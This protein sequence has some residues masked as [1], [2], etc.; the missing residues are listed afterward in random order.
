MKTEKIP[1]AVEANYKRLKPYRDS[2]RILSEQYTGANWSRSSSRK[3]QPLNFIELIV[4]TYLR[5][6]APARPR[7]MCE[8]VHGRRTLAPVCA[9]LEAACNHLLETIGFGDTIYR[10]ALEAMFS[11]GVA[12]VGLEQTGWIELVDSTHEVG[13]PFVD[14]V[15]LDDVVMDMSANRWDQMLFIG[16]CWTVPFDLA[17]DEGMFKGQWRRSAESASGPPDEHMH[18]GSRRT[19][20]LGGSHS[21][22]ADEGIERIVRCWTIYLPHS[23]RIVKWLAKPDGTP[24][25]K[26]PWMDD[27]WTGPEGG[28]YHRLGYNEVPGNLMPLPPVANIADLNLHLNEVM[29]KVMRQMKRQKTIIGVRAG[30]G[31]DATRINEADDGETIRMDDPAS[32][33]EAS[34]G[35]ADPATAALIP[36]LRSLMSYMAGNLDSLAGLSAAADTL[37]QER[38]I[39]ASSSLRI[40]DM[41]RKTSDFVRGVVKQIAWYVWN[42]PVVEYPGEKPIGGTGMTLP[43]LLTAEKRELMEW[44][45]MNVS[46]VPYS[47]QD[48][49]PTE[50]AMFI[51][52]MWDRMVAAAPVLAQQGLV[53]SAEAL[54]SNLAELTNI[55]ELTDIVEQ[56]GGPP[57]QGG[58]PGAGASPQP[59]GGQPREYIRRNIPGASREGQDQVLTSE[60]LGSRRQ[61]AESASVGRPIG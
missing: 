50:R 25:G 6:V 30:S 42:D 8:P 3:A 55:S 20:T 46:I 36:M 29:R 41:Q 10:I 13:V 53:P 17:M 35:G 54:L 23:N 16:D 1:Q 18:G 14:C 2:R 26:D 7:V 4:N 56:V 59:G 61:P 43:T 48:R 34:F 28:P 31:D 60:L 9:T 22:G 37:G 32:M 33:K 45:D 58:Q 5:Q 47:M 11:V 40:V 19:S 49:S 27:E 38:L 15:D 21:Y 24:Y 57:M 51:L 12:K 52:Q 44:M 39:D